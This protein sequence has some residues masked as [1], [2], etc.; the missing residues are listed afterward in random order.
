M[1]V[2]KHF[3][4]RFPK[5]GRVEGRN[6]KKTC[7]EILPR[8]AASL[9]VRKRFSA[10]RAVKLEAATPGDGAPDFARGCSDSKNRVDRRNGV[11]LSH[12]VV[13]M[14]PDRSGCGLAPNREEQDGPE[15]NI[16]LIDCVQIRSV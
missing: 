4:S 5:R 9:K 3:R 7:D 15:E 2:R 10:G 8:F 11:A 13:T 14:S 12:F 6:A 16:Q 1:K